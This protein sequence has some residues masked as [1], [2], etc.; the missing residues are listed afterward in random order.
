MSTTR[1]SINPAPV[2]DCVFYNQAAN[3]QLE[4]NC[5]ASCW[6]PLYNKRNPYVQEEMY[7]RNDSWPTATGCT[8]IPSQ[9]KGTYLSM[10]ISASRN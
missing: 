9:S 4:F 8:N 5:A 2:G 1:N 7:C 6:S 10:S 3:G